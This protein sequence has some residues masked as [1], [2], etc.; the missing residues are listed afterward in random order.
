MKI[1]WLF[2]WKFALEYNM[3]MWL[4]HWPLIVKHRHH[5]TCDSNMPAFLNFFSFF[6]FLLFTFPHIQI[7]RFPRNNPTAGDE[8]IIIRL[9][10]HVDACLWRENLLSL[11]RENL[12]FI[13]RLLY[14]SLIFFFNLSD[15][16]QTLVME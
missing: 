3:G 1:F 6:S 14:S 7:Q 9:T 8:D 12:G 11:W 16:P 10:A 15:R 4:R 2:S 5:Y 13:K